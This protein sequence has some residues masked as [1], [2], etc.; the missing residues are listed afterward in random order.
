MKPATTYKIAYAII[1]VGLAA[2]LAGLLGWIHP[3]RCPACR[4]KWHAGERCK[5][6]ELEP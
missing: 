6:P 3:R 1:A 5:W 4:E 2:D